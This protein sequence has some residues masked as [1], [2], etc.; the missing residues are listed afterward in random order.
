MLLR[1]AK[2]RKAHLSA[3]ILDSRT[4]RSTRESGPRTGYDGA[5]RKRGSK[6]H[7]AVDILGYLLAL[8][9]TPANKQDRAQVEQMTAWVQA[10]TGD[11]VEVAYVDQ[12]YTEHQPTRMLQPIASN[13]KS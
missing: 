11:V 10:V 4:L 12:G 8:H 6:V 1:L 2:G 5:K 13:S 3:A 7:R 9:V